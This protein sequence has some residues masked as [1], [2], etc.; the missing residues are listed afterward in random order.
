MR[1]D[2]S[3]EEINRQFDPPAP[4]DA[5]E[6]TSIEEIENRW[7][8]PDENGHYL[9]DDMKLNEIQF[10]GL[11]GTEADME[12]LR[13]ALPNNRW[14]DGVLSYKFDSGVTAENK[15]KV[16]QAMNDFNEHL[17]GCLTVKEDNSAQ[18]VVKVTGATDSGCWSSVGMNGGEQ[19]LQLNPSG[20][21]SSG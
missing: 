12:L 8:V 3:I 15:D 1:Q 13:N 2:T 9:I 17:T 14:T 5:R 16:R 10:K 18:N 19:R 11:F 7:D 4:P 21:M 20:C 6:D